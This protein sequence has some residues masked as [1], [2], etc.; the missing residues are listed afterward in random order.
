[1]GD[2]TMRVM[3]SSF[4][5][6]CNWPTARVS[7]SARL[8]LISF[9]PSTLSLGNLASSYS[10][11]AF[12]LFALDEDVGDG[13]NDARDQTAKQ[14]GNHGVLLLVR[15]GNVR[16]SPCPCRCCSV[17]SSRRLG[18]EARQEE[19]EGQGHACSGRGTLRRRRVCRW[20]LQLVQLEASSTRNTC[21][22]QHLLGKLRTVLQVVVPNVL[23]CCRLHLPEAERRTST[24]LSA[25]AIAALG[26]D[27]SRR[28][29]QQQHV[30]R[31]GLLRQGG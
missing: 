5:E 19:G 20:S 16:P 11:C 2:V 15:R 3:Y 25:N 10:S 26:Q 30:H 27:L 24:M 22:F 23:V 29:V 18:M 1:M 17:P 28:A 7:H 13:L 12:A 4:Q 14:L 31:R 8:K 21:D 9:V 6:S